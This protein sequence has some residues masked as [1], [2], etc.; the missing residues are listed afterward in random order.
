MTI[1]SGLHKESRD[2]VA[3]HRVLIVD[4][5]LAILFAYRKLIEAEGFEVDTCENIYEAM[6]LI[7]L[8]AYLAI[9]TDIRLAGTEN[10]DGIELLQ[11]IKEIQPDSRVIVTTG[12][13][14]EEL[15]RTTH[16]LGAAHYFEK[17]VVPADIL[18][19]ITNP[20]NSKRHS[21]LA[22]MAGTC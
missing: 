12:Y 10:E 2:P 9:I 11:F 18:S 8:C 14:N 1:Q 22:G 21:N 16:S 5:E 3:K 7:R 20:G 13:G 17:P 6:A 15:K 19:A 4:D